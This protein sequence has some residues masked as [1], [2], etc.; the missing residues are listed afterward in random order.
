MGNQRGAVNQR[1]KLTEGYR[2]VLVYQ[3]EC[4]SFLWLDVIKALDSLRKPHTL[5]ADRDDDVRPS[6][7]ANYEAIH[8][9]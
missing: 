6:G 7:R 4:S 3:Q 5:P 9:H 1:Q 8:E 2:G